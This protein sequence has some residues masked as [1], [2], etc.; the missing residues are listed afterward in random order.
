VAKKLLICIDYDETFSADPELWTSFIL[1]AKERGHEVICATM[2]YESDGYALQK[3]IG[4]HCR[5]IYTG[6][7]AKLPFLHKMN[8]IPDIWIDD[9]PFWI[10]N[11]AGDRIICPACGSE[12]VLPVEPFDNIRMCEDCNHQISI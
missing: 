4:K 1:S 12:K 5:I 11:D 2:R 6:R 10:L 3:S 7:V 9:K 8:I